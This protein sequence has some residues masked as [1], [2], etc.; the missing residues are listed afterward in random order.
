M[1]FDLVQKGKELE[2]GDG[3]VGSACVVCSLASAFGFRVY[4]Y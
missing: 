2:G 3:I 4:T 1:V